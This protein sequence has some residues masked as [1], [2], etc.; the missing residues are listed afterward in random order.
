MSDRWGSVAG[1]QVAGV[2]EPLDDARCTGLATL[3]SLVAALTEPRV[4]AVDPV[5]LLEAP[6]PEALSALVPDRIDFLV[7]DLE[8]VD[9]AKAVICF[10][11]ACRLGMAQ[12]T[13]RFRG[14]SQP[15]LFTIVDV[16]HDCGVLA[17]VFSDDA[18]APAPG[19]TPPAPRTADATASVIVTPGA[20]I[21]EVYGA[22]PGVLGA[23]GADVLGASLGAFLHPD[24]TAGAVVAFAEALDDH[25]MGRHLRARLRTNDGD[26]RWIDC[27]LLAGTRPDGDEVYVTCSLADVDAEVRA[28]AALAESEERF[29]QLAESIP[30]G[31]FGARE[32]RVHYANKAF[33]EISVLDDMS[34]WLSLVHP[35]DLEEA[36][37]ALRQFG[38]GGEV[39]DIEI[40]VRDDRDGRYRTLRV[41]ARAIRAEDG[42]ILDVVGS[43]E[44]ISDR[45]ALQV[46]L[47]H[48]ATHDA[49]T[50]LANRHHLVNELE[51][52]L[53]SSF[54]GRDPLAVLFVDL[55]GFK[56]VND[57]LGHTAGDQLLLTCARRLADQARVGDLVSRFGGDE[58]VIVAEQ[59]GGPDGA[60]GM[61]HRVL[62]AISEPA[63]VAGTQVRPRASIGVALAV[64]A[65]ADPETLLRDAD[66][67]MYEAKA[68]GP[69]GVWLADAA[70]RGRANRRFGLEAALADALVAD[71]YR[72][73]YQPIVSLAD[74]ALLGAEGLFR[75]DSPQFGSP[76]PGEVLPLAEETGLIHALTDWTVH[77]VGRDLLYLRD[78]VDFEANFQLGINLSCTQLSSPTCVDRYLAGLAAMSLTPDEVVVEVTET[79]LI[80]ESSVAEASLSAL[81]AAG[82]QLAVDDF[83]AG[84]SSFDYL[85]RMP[86]TFLKIDR[87]LTRALPTNVRARRVLRGLVSMCL[88]MGVI[89]VGEG[90]ETVDERDAYLEIGIEFGQGFLYSP[91]LPVDRLAEV[92]QAGRQLS[93]TP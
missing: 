67:A 38:D 29:R 51:R 55:D 82:A 4:Y 47:A 65:D 54:S 59:T 30:L 61:A 53:A 86:V 39:L 69:N 40:R 91:A 22:I 20:R 8:P 2:T 58:F 45:K 34:D 87:R 5:S 33:R 7:D 48:E 24:D 16:V 27:T 92:L 31:V 35:N 26:Y 64:D 32:G 36:T 28:R 90:V 79:E 41:L 14:A 62:E 42:S 12:V 66:A 52:R 25:R 6:V 70:V 71:E 80:E 76:S 56:R 3:R 17:Y 60:L 72:L 10:E 15:S 23:D 88:D 11:E 13:V 43:M 49:L 68:R 50:G 85:T 9:H 93:I 81:A 77:R 73:D 46:R 21:I 84:Y 57:S 78:R 63:E 83:G 74:G 75:W 37:T 89:V 44:D 1:E 18:L 19:L